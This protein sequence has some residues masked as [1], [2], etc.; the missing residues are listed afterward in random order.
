[1]T[2][3]QPPRPTPW[4]AV[5]GGFPAGV[6]LRHLNQGEINAVRRTWQLQGSDSL[7]R[8]LDD[9][10]DQLKAAHS[11]YN[12]RSN[13]G[14]V[15]EL[16]DRTRDEVTIT[17]PISPQEAAE[18]LECTDRN[19][20]LLAEREAIL[21]VQQRGRWILSRASVLAY[22]DARAGEAEAA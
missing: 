8:A 9:A 3:Y 18:L 1:M 13:L 7:V 21:G 20:R 15:P 10:L 19:V 4:H 2:A 16:V 12:R 14:M 6:I 17:D 22:R 5:I 11:D